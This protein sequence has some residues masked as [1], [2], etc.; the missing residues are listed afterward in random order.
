[1]ETRKKH[2]RKKIR[3]LISPLKK[4]DHLSLEEWQIA[5]RRQ[6]VQDSFLRVKNIGAHPVFSDFEVRNVK[7]D[8]VYR[9]VVRGET[10]GINYCSCLD[11]EVNTLGTCK[12]IERVLS[13]LRKDKT[14]HEALKKPHV[15]EHSSVTL[16]YGVKRRVY[17]STGKTASPELRKT[18]EAYFDPEGYLTAGGFKQFDAFMETVKTL[19][20]DVH[21]HPDA[22]AFIAKARDEENR[23]VRIGKL[24]SRKNGPP[25]EK[26]IKADLYPY[27]KAGV[28]FA[29]QAG[30]CLIADEMGLGKTLQAIAATG[31]MARI[32]GIEKV[33][34][35]CPSSLKYQWRQEIEKFTNR[36][37]QVIQGL[38]HSRQEQY[39][40]TAFFKIVNY[41]V[42]HRDLAAIGKWSPDLI[43]L[44]EAQ[45]I[46]NWK[47]RLAKS[48]K[49]LSSPYAIVLTG[50]PLE[51]RIEE[52]H[53]IV[54]F[55]DR[56]HLG[57]LFRFLNAHQTVDPSGKVVGY[58]DL[59]R[60]GKTLES[61]LIRRSKKEV[62][63]QLPERMDKNYFVKLEP[64]QRQIHEENREKAAR[65]IHKW[66]KY[67]FLSDEDQ[68]C[69]MMALQNMRMVCDN[70]YLLDQQTI[71]G[72]KIDELEILLREIF[73][74]PKNKV[75]I[76]SQ[77]VRMGE[78]VSAMFKVNKWKYVYLHGS[79]SS[80]KR[81][82]MIKT[83]K[84]DPECRV[85]LSTDAGGTG[86]NLQQ[87]SVVINLD[88]PWNPAVLEQ[89]IGRVHRL[90]QQ[91]AVQ[92]INFVAEDS[93][94]QGMLS[95]YRFKK[96]MFAGVLD[97]G[98]NEV[99]M[100]GGRLNKFMKTVE[101][102]T[103]SLKPQAAGDREIE[104]AE[105]KEEKNARE[106]TDHDETFFAGNEPPS[107]TRVP[108]QP[109][110]H[111]IKSGIAWLSRMNDSMGKNTD[112]L[113]GAPQKDAFLAIRRDLET[114]RQTLQIPL[115]DEKT[116][117]ALCQA[118]SEI[119]KGFAAQQKR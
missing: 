49:Q 88:L 7:T 47:T 59:H 2:K 36:T 92:V 110:N 14:A 16:R 30:R 99:F 32:Y 73:E 22:M 87:A 10:P 89:R 46:K 44:D 86:L 51:N 94:E 115:P 19:K 35:V 98:Q 54:E 45:R 27:Q 116:V 26:L 11:F 74:N 38:W 42:V 6:I 80:S 50:T 111:L 84:E 15:S 53:S 58:K 20:A 101:S 56:N 78:L 114:G 28:L 57:P 4:P 107:Q 60:L 48:V 93:I 75:V 9:V 8:R 29:A 25:W 109:L 5:L 37:A 69:L 102:A 31:L 72:G 33:L 70:T 67:H 90:G 55:I 117:A 1:V 39:E 12:H 66:Q 62:L 40:R 96:S 106:E 112:A 24:T 61:I 3:N 97:G 23:R 118:F 91:Q 83:F 81:G 65:F 43:I 113:G 76:F 82:D 21:F 71:K 103:S 105:K 68:Q 104:E 77:W 52:L 64:E 13:K 108:V 100:E 63:P 41:D 79:V 119:L 17:F 18:A 34:I 95:L 85:F